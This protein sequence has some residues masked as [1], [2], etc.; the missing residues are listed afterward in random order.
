M[1][2]AEID[3][4]PKP[5]FRFPARQSADRVARQV[6]RDQTIETDLA[7]PLV[8]STLDNAEQIV[9]FGM[10]VRGQTPVNPPQGAMA[11]FFHSRP[12][13]GAAHDIVQCHNNVGPDLSLHLDGFFWCQDHC[14]AV[15]RRLETNA[16]LSYLGKF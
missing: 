5:V 11:G 3:H 12:S 4:S 13:Y 2:R 15:M 10:N 6:P 8:K 7:Q 16:F 14:G 1:V 9:T